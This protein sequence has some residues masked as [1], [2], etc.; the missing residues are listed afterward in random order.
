LPFRD[1]YD[2]TISRLTGKVLCRFLH[3]SSI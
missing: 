1:G 3:P 2:N